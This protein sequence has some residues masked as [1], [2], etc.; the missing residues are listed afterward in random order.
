MGGTRDEIREEAEKTNKDYQQALR[1]IEEFRLLVDVLHLS[2]SS[3]SVVVTNKQNTQVLKSTLKHRIKR[4]HNF[5]SHISSRAKAQFT[6]LLSERSF[7]GKLLA[8][9][10][11]KVLDLQVS[12]YIK[13]IPRIILTL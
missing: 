8:D 3:T 10:E 11:N 1:Q 13:P 4:W 5:R 6:Y 2:I 9:H 7:R 12:S